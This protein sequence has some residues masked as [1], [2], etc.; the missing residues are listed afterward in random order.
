M[1]PSLDLLRMIFNHWTNSHITCRHD[2]LESSTD[3]DRRS[4]NG[5]T[6]I[7]IEWFAERHCQ[8]LTLRVYRV[9]WEDD[10][11]I[12]KWK[13]SGRNRSWLNAR[14]YL[15]LS[16]RDYVNPRIPSKMTDLL[17]EILILVLRDIK[18]KCYTIDNEFKKLSDFLRKHPW[19]SS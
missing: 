12:M 19:L 7:T 17:M 15:G 3:F 4:E 14:L 8:N 11:G 2:L 1:L 9:E 16:S 18:Q 6:F 10:S 5:G 13:V